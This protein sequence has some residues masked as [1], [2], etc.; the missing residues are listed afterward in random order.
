MKAEE[1]LMISLRTL[2]KEGHKDKCPVMQA[3]HRALDSY[4]TDK[5]IDDMEADTGE[6]HGAC[7]FVYQLA[8]RVIE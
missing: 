6:E 3:L 8:D 1:R 5:C 7:P 2:M 4:Q